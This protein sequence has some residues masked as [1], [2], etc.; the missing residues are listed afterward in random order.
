MWTDNRRIQYINNGKLC[1]DARMW[2]NDGRRTPTTEN[3]AM[4]KN[5]EQQQKNSISR[6]WKLCN[7]ARMWNNNRK[8]S[9]TTEDCTRTETCG[10]IMK[11][12]DQQRKKKNINYERRSLSMV[13]D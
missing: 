5:V 8:G 1:N 12:A 2:N 10:M 4:M 3:G 13:E 7:D 6:Q 9:P 11:N